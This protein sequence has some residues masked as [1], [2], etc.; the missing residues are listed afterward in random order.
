MD[1]IIFSEKTR[2]P[3]GS[4]SELLRDNR[5]DPSHP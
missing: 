5:D 2:D 4:S 3:K 1:P